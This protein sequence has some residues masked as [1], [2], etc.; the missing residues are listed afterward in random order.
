MT[1]P[2]SKAQRAAFEEALAENATET[3]R[4]VFT[5]Q[6]GVL[7]G[8]TLIAA[9][10][11]EALFS[12]IRVPSTMVLKD[13]SH[14]TAFPVW[15]EGE[16]AGIAAGVGDIVLKPHPETFR[17]LPWSPRSAWVL[18]SACH[19]DGAPFSIDGRTLLSAQ[20]DALSTRGMA[21]VC[22]LEVECH[23]FDVTD[24]RLDAG[25]ATMPPRAPLV[26]MLDRG[27]NLL[28]E[29]R[30]DA[31][32]D[33]LDTIRTACTAL[34]LPLRS[35]EVEMGPSQFEFTFSPADPLTQA[36]NMVLFRAAVKAVCQ[37]AG[38]HATFMSRPVLDNCAASGWHLHQSLVDRE[39]G[40]NLFEPAADGA[41]SQ[42]ASHWIAGLLD[43]AAACC[44]LT[45]PTVNGYKRYRP[46]QLAP[47]RLCW[48]MDNRGAMIRAIM[49]G[50]ASRVE[51]RVAE[52]AANPYFTFAAQIA[53]GLSG[54]KA[55]KNAPPPTENPYNTNTAP[56]LPANLGEAISAFEASTTLHDAFG[57]D[58]V[59]W[60]A[61]IKRAE[62]SRYLATLSQW[63]QDEYFSIF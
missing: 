30:Y 62:W 37:R 36:D 9:A 11:V 53:S 52:P 17:P 34:G 22:G 57:R 43:N 32:E 44:V 21:M 47:D 60:Y 6:H 33:I 3:V 45:T 41:L 24:D 15:E 19:R 4:F 39:T 50:A 29:A 35:I 12:G 20:I 28:T 40:A 58:F 54:L 55:A 51:N 25:D 26:R 16:V 63:E 13:T 38:L 42:A 27:Y 14:R 56:R 8:K 1:F 5:D 49:D 31:A 18:C 10:A 46:G 48:G 59:T 2:I 7:R 61:T 23:I